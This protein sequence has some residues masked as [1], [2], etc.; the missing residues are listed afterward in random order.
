MMA[1]ELWVKLGSYNAVEVSTEGCRNVDKFLKACK[2]E[3]PRLL[4]AYD[5][6]Q[7]SLSTTAGGP[8]LRPG[9]LLSDI[10]SQP[11]YVEN[12]AK[13]PLFIS[14][15]DS[16]ALQPLVPTFW[17]ATGSITGARKMGFCRGISDALHFRAAVYENVGTVSPQ[18]DLTVSLSVDLASDAVLDEMI[19]VGH[20]VRDD[21]SPPDTSRPLSGVTELFNTSPLFRYQRLEDERYFGG[22]YKADRAH[23]I[24]KPLCERG[25]RF[26]KFQDNENNFLALSKRVHCWFDA[27]SNVSEKIPFFK[28]MIKHVSS[29]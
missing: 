18:G 20:Y 25:K 13:A 11:G 27:L 4:D 2:R 3:L 26:A 9:L 17:R 8:A 24:D 21:D 29:S 19:L 23:L 15:A 7:L 10:L 28:L 16:S 1:S 14:V 5:S 22:L 12:T 6:A